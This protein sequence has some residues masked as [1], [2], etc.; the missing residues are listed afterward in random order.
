[1][2]RLAGW[3]RSSGKTENGSNSS[4]TATDSIAKEKENLVEAMDWIE[5]IMNDDI[6]GAWEKLQTGDSSFHE[7]GS[8]VAFFMRS[9]LGFEKQIM[10]EATARLNDCETRAWSDLKR[11]QKHGAAYN[12]SKLYPPG[13]EYELIIAET[14][15]MGAV[16]G[17]LHESLVEAMKSFYKLRKAFLTLDAIVTSEETIFK[18]PTPG[19][20]RMSLIG[21]SSPGDGSE[22]ESNG[23]TA[24]PSS[25]SETF[26][27]AR[28]TLSGLQTPSDQTDASSTSAASKLEKLSISK[29]EDTSK[30]SLRSRDSDLSSDVELDNPVDKF[31]HSGANMCFGVLLLIL[32]LIPPAFSRILSVVG[33]HGD[34]RR[35]VK[36]LWKSAVH[37]NINGAVAGMMLLVYYNGLLGAADILPDRKDYDEDAEAVGPPIEKCEQL[38]ADMRRR[39]P[40]SQLWRVEESRMLANERKITEALELL[41]SG[42]ESKMKQVAALNNF[43][44]SLD[45]MMSYEWMLMRDSFLRCLEVNDW[46]PSLYY[47]LA[48]CASLELYRDAFHSGDKDEAR[49]QK[50]KTEEF[51][52]KAPTV[53]GKK[54]LM[55]RQLPLETFLQRKVQKWEDRAKALG[56]DLADVAGSSPALEMCYV[57]NGQKRMGTAQLEKGLDYLKWERC[58]ASREVVA[59]IQEEKDEMAVWAVSM[60]SLLRGL[61]RL[62]EAR[63]LLQEKVIAYDRSVFKGTSKDDYVLPS[64]TYELGAIAWAECCDPPEGE[65]KE[66]LEFRRKKMLECEE[67]L[68]KVKVWEA[69]ALD[70]RIG[71]RAQSGLETLAWFKK[72]NG[73]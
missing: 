57:W 28:E 43:E 40:D 60:A 50:A 65:A 29:L 5:L 27:D 4:L 72:K 44:L 35:A 11:A 36:M 16:V 49:R 20:S 23:N 73:W 53:T 41:K 68:N 51:F 69:Y 2:S 31:I 61:G 14:Q 45:A 10:T 52:R 3:F 33:F 55:A 54:R 34:R 6:D 7:M 47:Y 56:V 67:Q 71:L 1:M 48:G 42:K 12:S 17:V 21:S 64:A 32:S 15:L 37:S 8:A 62:D 66:I 18:K 58:T 13:T 70:T 46:S 22:T 38:L 59:K 9:V 39:Y 63:T 19:S 24:T 26:V 25:D 30:L